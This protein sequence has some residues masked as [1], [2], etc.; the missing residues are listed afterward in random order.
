MDILAVT[1]GQAPGVIPAEIRESIAGGLMSWREAD[2]SYAALRYLFAHT[3]ALGGGD[4]L[5]LQWPRGWQGPIC[6]NDLTDRGVETGG[7]IE[8]AVVSLGSMLW[9][10]GVKTQAVMELAQLVA[11]VS[12]PPEKKQKGNVDLKPLPSAEKKATALLAVME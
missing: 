2:R 4:H 8:D 3:S 11:A 1:D 10:N 5:S 6:L 9:R 7:C 12:S